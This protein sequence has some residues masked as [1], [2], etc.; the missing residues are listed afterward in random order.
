MFPSLTD[1]CIQVTV[2]LVVG[3]IFKIVNAFPVIVLRLKSNRFMA[4]QFSNK[5]CTIVLVMIHALFT[6]YLPNFTTETW[7]LLSNRN[8]SLLMICW[9]KTVFLFIMWTL[10][11]YLHVRIILLLK[12]NNLKPSQSFSNTIGASYNWSLNVKKNYLL[13]SLLILD[14]ITINAYL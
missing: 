1:N 9:L 10:L 3:F 8:F 6:W 2:L 7:K 4:G 12:S 14:A 11:R 5:C 13:I